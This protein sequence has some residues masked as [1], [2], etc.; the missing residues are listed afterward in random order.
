MALYFPLPTPRPRGSGGFGGY[1]PEGADGRHAGIDWFARAGTSVRAPTWGRVIEV[2]RGGGRTGQVYGGVVKIL[3][4][5]GRVWVFRHVAPAG[6]RVGQRVGPGDVIARV[7]PWSGPTHAH[8][9]LWRSRGGGYRFS[10]ML[11]PLSVLAGGRA[12]R[13]GGG[14]APP[15]RQ[16]GGD[17][18]SLLSFRPP[19]VPVP[20]LRLP[21]PE[22]VLAGLSAD[23]IGRNL[24]QL[25]SP[26]A[27]P[28]A[29]R[30]SS[31]SSELRSLRRMLL[32]V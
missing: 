11:N 4:P 5:N 14:G 29:E 26:A 23:A 16:G 27:S 2:K 1:S 24:E 28:L 3:R 19:Q 15:T 13:G 30:T 8:I 18:L 20:E 10:N 17:L 12:H 32:G 21:R 7:A 31:L 9:E 6:V 22:Q 25:P